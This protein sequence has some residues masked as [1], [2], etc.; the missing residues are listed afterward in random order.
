MENSS[1]I[2]EL[3]Q[4]TTCDVADGLLNMY[5]IADGGYFPNLTQRS[6]LSGSKSSIA[7]FTYNVL[8]APITDPRPTVNY[9]DSIPEGA[10]LICT[11]TL[12]LQ[13]SNEP[14]TRVTQAMFGGLMARRAQY[15]K[16]K[17]SVIFGRVR[18]IPELVDLQYP[19]F[20]YGVGACASKLAVKPVEVDVP[21]EIKTDEQ[22]VQV[23]HPGDYVLLDSHGMVRIPQS[24]DMKKLIRYVK[25]SIEVDELVAQDISNGIHAKLA[26]SNRRSILKD[27]I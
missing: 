16:S 1:I 12:P 11:L 9:V 4:F 27:Y 5:K 8:F 26:Q 3:E 19:V 22:T 21:L 17:A 25:K 18:D 15:L 23:I 7:G 20:S 14:Y 24:V 2:N 10:V 13:A 6:G